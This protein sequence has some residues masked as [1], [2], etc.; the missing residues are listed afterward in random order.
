VSFLAS[1]LVL[2]GLLTVG[3]RYL[4]LDIPNQRSLHAVSVPRSGG[5]AIIIGSW[6]GWSFLP[7]FPRLLFFCSLGL[8]CLS[9][10]D[11]KY[12]LPVFPRLIVQALVIAFFLSS[13]T[14]SSLPLSILLFA[15]IWITNLYNFMDGSDGLAGG[16]TII[17]FGAYALA[18]GLAGNPTFSMLNLCIA[19]GAIPF[20]VL[21]FHPAKIF[22]GDVGSIPLGFLAGALGFTGWQQGIW[23]LWY[24]LLVFAPFIADT[25]ITLLKRIVARQK[26]WLPH[27]GHYYQRFLVMGAGHR[28]TFFVEFMLMMAGGCSAVAGLFLPES[29][30][31]LLL[32]SWVVIYIFLAMAV[33]RRWKRFSNEAT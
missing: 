8:L 16:M 7:N 19:M 15:L 20:L 14:S 22:M 10:L 11:D 25:S 23:P 30:Q 26:F 28:N 32:M 9:W 31:Y 13:T 21:N 18:A 12:H 33:D 24:P 3:R 5:M 27:R 1:L 6:L 2:G 29:V 17:G 4:K